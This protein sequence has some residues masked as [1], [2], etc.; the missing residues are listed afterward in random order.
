M[1]AKES[2][3]HRVT[4]MMSRL[5]PLLLLL[6]L[7]IWLSSTKADDN[8]GWHGSTNDGGATLFFGIPNT[9]YAPLSFACSA[10]DDEL[11]FTHTRHSLTARKSIHVRVELQAD[12]VAVPIDT[13][14]ARLDLDDTF[15]MQGKTTLD[16]RLIALLTSRGTLLVFVDD[17][18]QAFPLD[19]ARQAVSYLLN[20]CRRQ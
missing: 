9:D 15:M 4:R 3:K 19:G 10:Q 16:D 8:L 20:V 14:G 17:V 11:T 7:L 5:K 12:N 13:V 2:E 18:A 6:T 1:I